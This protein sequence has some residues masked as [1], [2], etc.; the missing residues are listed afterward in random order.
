MITLNIERGEEGKTLEIF[1]S[2]RLSS[3][4]KGQYYSYLR[5]KCF[6]INGVHAQTGKEIL[7][8]GDV[9][10]FFVDERLFDAEAKSSALLEIVYE[11]DKIIVAHKP[12][13]MLSHPDEKLHEPDFLSALCQ[14]KKVPMGTYALVNRLDFNTSGLILVGKDLS[15]TRALNDA[16]FQ[17]QIR[18][19]YR[20]LTY[21]Y[22]DK[23]TA[24]LHAYLLK[25]EQSS[26]VRISDHPMPKAQ[27]IRTKYTVLQEGNGLS[28]LEIELMTGK[29]H[30]IRAHLASVDHP[31]LGDP[32][33]GNE[34]I[35]K[36][37][38]VA[39]QALWASKLVFEISDSHSPLFYLSQKV[40]IKDEPLWSRFLKK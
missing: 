30:Q 7:R 27:E 18:K 34:V 32:L 23:P 10:T 28:L 11:D 19:F 38:G 4:T 39:K 9:L 20:C 31:I 5:K 16:A 17:G 13:G 36:R 21:G 25:D 1:V 6:K 8:E 15:S 40:I 12:E 2:K 24:E 35:N 22:W 3:L 33:Y 29:T 26:L 14:Q 37:Y